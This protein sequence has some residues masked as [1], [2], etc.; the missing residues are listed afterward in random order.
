MRGVRREPTRNVYALRAVFGL[1]TELRYN[2]NCDCA[3]RDF[4]S[5]IVIAG[6]V[7]NIA[8]RARAVVEA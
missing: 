7:A 5:L 8:I 3:S 4:L 6:P 1:L 2:P